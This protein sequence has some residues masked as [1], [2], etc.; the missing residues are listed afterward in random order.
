MHVVEITTKCGSIELEELTK[1]GS[2]CRAS[3]SRGHFFGTTATVLAA[4]CELP[5]DDDW[6]QAIAAAWIESADGKRGDPAMDV[7]TDSK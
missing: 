7:R 4:A 1:D 3:T 6:V 5:V 2:M